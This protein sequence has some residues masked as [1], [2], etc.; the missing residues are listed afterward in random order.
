MAED[1]WW[2]QQVYQLGAN[3]QLLPLLQSV[4]LMGMATVGGLP[5]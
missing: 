1:V 5:C 4:S 2:L 3:Q